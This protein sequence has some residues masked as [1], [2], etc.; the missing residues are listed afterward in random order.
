VGKGIE[1]YE[2]EDL[3]AGLILL[4]SL[5]RRFLLILKAAQTV[6]IFVSIIFSRI[7]NT[8]QNTSYFITADFLAYSV[9]QF[10]K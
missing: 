8:L 3:P 9:L 4:M 7:N 1:T 5:M 10:D 2:S 6:L